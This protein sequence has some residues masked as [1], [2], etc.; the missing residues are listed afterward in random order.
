MIVT[1]D[2]TTN[3]TV[4]NPLSAQG[5]WVQHRFGKRN[6]P[7]TELPVEKLLEVIAETKASKYFLESA[8]GD[9]L[10]YSHINELLDADADFVI[11]SYCNINNDALF[12]KIKEK[13]CIVA[14]NISGIDEFDSSVFLHSDWNVISKNLITLGSCAYITFWLYEHNQHQLKTLVDFCYKYGNNLQVMPGVALHQGYSSIIDEQGSWL[15]DVV[16]TSTVI[17]DS[18][19]SGDDLILLSEKADK[20]VSQNAKVSQSLFCYSTLRTFVKEQKG[21]SIL[22]Y[23]IVP[24]F[25][26]F[27]VEK[28]FAEIAITVTGHVFPNKALAD[29]FSHTLCDDWK[30]DRN[31]FADSYRAEII[32]QLNSIT[33]MNLDCVNLHT[34]TFTDILSYLS[35]SD[36]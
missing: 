16:S 22:N 26:P 8:Y 33:A 12:H 24:N 15:Y 31:D 35:D 27:Q 36:I 19:I 13:N 17:T 20:L 5:S 25:E 18:F 9:A 30:F 32:K 1:F 3:N 34:H 6:Y 21:R 11:R 2:L 10:C 28:P 14:V 4:F 7:E 23:P 29:T